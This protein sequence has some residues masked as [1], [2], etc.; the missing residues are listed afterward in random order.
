MGE[1]KPQNMVAGQR[2]LH[3]RC[4]E[5]VAKKGGSQVRS[6]IGCH[7]DG[8]GFFVEQSSVHSLLLLLSGRQPLWSRFPG[9]CMGCQHEL[10]SEGAPGTAASEAALQAS[11]IEGPTESTTLPPAS[12]T[13]AKE[14]LPVSER[15]A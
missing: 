15:S 5:L 6:V 10:A 8:N 2:W 11:K 14:P 7:L 4:L 9:L 3:C 13:T 12:R 1:L